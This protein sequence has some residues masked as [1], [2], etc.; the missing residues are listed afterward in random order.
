MTHW[1][2]LSLRHYLSANSDLPVPLKRR[3]RSTVA[4]LTGEKAG[5]PRSAGRTQT[6]DL[7]ELRQRVK[8]AGERLGEAAEED[9]KR[10]E[11]LSSLLSVVEEGFARS[12]Q[13]IKRS[14]EDLARANDEIQQLRTMLQTPLAEG[15][16][17]G[18]RE[19]SAMSPAIAEEVVE[20]NESPSAED[21]EE[22]EPLELTQ[23]VTEERAVVD[24]NA[25]QGQS[26]EKD[27][28]TLQ[29]N[30]IKRIAR[31]LR[32]EQEHDGRHQKQ[33]WRR[34]FGGAD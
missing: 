9:R 3:L 8:A 33:R 19:A 2:T 17:T 27:R 25:D 34:F 22:K 29:Q 6:T 21:G 12:Q 11:R 14:N 4:A 32:E 26:A 5:S 10:S 24:V 1:G 20:D 23:M 7:A 15:E 13:E 30:N 16:D 31:T 28:A 18:V